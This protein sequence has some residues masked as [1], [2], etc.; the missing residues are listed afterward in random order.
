MRLQTLEAANQVRN[1][2]DS[3]AVVNVRSG[4]VHHVVGDPSNPTDWQTRCGCRWSVSLTPERKESSVDCGICLCHFVLRTSF[5]S[6]V[7]MLC[8]SCGGSC[9]PVPLQLTLLVKDKKEG[10]EGRDDRWS[11]GQRKLSVTV[12]HRCKAV[13]RSGGME[14]HDTMS[15]LGIEWSVRLILKGVDRQR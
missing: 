2:S 7:P 6:M 3:L 9:A 15:R 8:W 10:R 11:L 1:A 5:L 12:C 4:V 13:C 14:C